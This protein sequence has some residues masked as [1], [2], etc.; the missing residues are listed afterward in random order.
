MDRLQTQPATAQELGELMADISA[1]VLSLTTALE[2][3][4]LLT[5][6]EIRE[7]AQ[8]RWLTLSAHHLPQHPYNLLRMMATQLPSR[9]DE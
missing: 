7:A 5:N 6:D 1:C 3:K 9:P 2:K 8:E 4:G